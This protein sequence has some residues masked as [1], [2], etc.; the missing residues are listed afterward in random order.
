MYN[1]RLPGK[2]LFLVKSQITHFLN[3]TNVSFTY[4]EN[5]KFKKSVF[6]QT[7]VE[8][9]YSRVAH[10]LRGRR[11]EHEPSTRNAVGVP[12]KVESH[13]TCMRMTRAGE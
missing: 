4:L 3:L 12:R 10:A 13:G 11:R 6:R 8:N 5:F 2:K 1:G 9:T 7:L